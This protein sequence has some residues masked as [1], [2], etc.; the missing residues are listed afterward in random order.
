MI[1]HRALTRE[2]S[3]REGVLAAVF[4]NVQVTEALLILLLVA[5]V[6]TPSVEVV[7]SLPKLRLEQVLIA[8]IAAA[9]VVMAVRRGASIQFGVIDL[10]FMAIAVS[11]L[12]GIVWGGLVLDVDIIGR[13]FFEVIKPFEYFLL[14]RLGISINEP[15]S[16]T[17]RRV[18]VALLIAGVVSATL[19]VFQYFGW[20]HVNDWLS[21]VFAP[22]HHLR[23]LESGGRVVGT[24]GAPNDYGIFSALLG[25]TAVSVFIFG[26]PS[27]SFASLLLFALGIATLTLL[28][29]LSR[30][31]TFGAL[32]A[33]L[34]ITILALTRRQLWPRLGAALVA[35][36]LLTGA[37]LGVLEAFPKEGGSFV[38]RFTSAMDPLQDRTLALRLL[39]WQSVLGGDSGGSAP[40]S[41]SLEPLTTVRATGGEGAPP[42][43]LERDAM[44]RADVH[45]IVPAL[46]EYRTE[47]GS[48][49]LE[50]EFASVLW[51]RYVAQ[52][53]ADRAEPEDSPLYFSKG[54]GFI[55]GNPLEN[56]AHADYPVYAIGSY[57]NLLRDSSFENSNSGSSDWFTLGPR[58]YEVKQGLA[59]YGE[60]SAVYQYSGPEPPKTG[61]PVPAAI[62]GSAPSYHSHRFHIRQPDFLPKR[63]VPSLHRGRLRRWRDG[64][65]HRRRPHRH[66][67]PLRVAAGA[68]HFHHRREAHRVHARLRPG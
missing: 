7:S 36:A 9:F 51:P 20:L 52:L 8:A 33:L 10:V 42:E 63:R 47:H 22:E 6:L 13:D 34:W 48:Y 62:P 60:H 4:A 39:R 35:L 18:V 44:R 21:P 24:I 57:P 67:R 23:A 54:T 41:V 14:F 3:Q 65:P 45:G 12:I 30:S 55:V 27:R 38:S 31:A 28:M 29:S 26:N 53:P 5:A 64:G 56:S 25:V 50:E 32:A 37:S 2:A 40:T 15:T 66:S 61:G 19:S 49:P 59:L 11:T 16:G 17:V 58:E 46:I 43:V 1:T 68:R